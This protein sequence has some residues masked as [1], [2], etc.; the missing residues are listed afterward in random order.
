MSTCVVAQVQPLSLTTSQGGIASA[1][2][3][4]AL[5]ALGA[6]VQ[7][8]A[9]L[10]VDDGGS[11]D[12]DDLMAIDDGV[13]TATNTVCRSTRPPYSANGP[14]PPPAPSSGALSDA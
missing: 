13:S 14:R 5:P 10:A 9:A 12:E 6:S 3:G 7:A 8:A 11:E 4:G 2:D 1:G